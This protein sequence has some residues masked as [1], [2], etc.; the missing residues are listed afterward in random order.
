[1]DAASERGIIVIHNPEA[2][3]QSTVEHTVALLMSMAARV[4][5]G[6]RFLR[7]DRTIGREDMRGT[8]LKGRNLG[9]S[10]M[11]ESVAAWRRS[12]PSDSR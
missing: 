6:D 12:A 3:T 5:A 10:A 7:G 1:M 2:P 9:L 4:M 8:E 11:A